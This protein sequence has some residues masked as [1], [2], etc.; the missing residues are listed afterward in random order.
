MSKN[1]IKKCY[2]SYSGNSKY[3]KS[4]EDLAKTFY[5]KNY[6]VKYRSTKLDEKS[7]HAAILKSEIVIVLVTE[8][9]FGKKIALK[10]FSVA[11]ENSKTILCLFTPGI[12]DNRNKIEN[13]TLK[14]M[15][16]LMV[17]DLPPE[18][19][20][21]NKWSKVI[22]DT[23]K[24]IEASFKDTRIKSGKILKEKNTFKIKSDP[25]I[26]NVEKHIMLGRGTVI[27]KTELAIIAF[28]E[29]S[30]E[31]LICTF[32]NQGDLLNTKNGKEIHLANPEL[33]ASNKN[34]E[35]YITNSNG[36]LMI[37]NNDLKLKSHANFE[38]TNYS[39]MAIDE[40]SN[41]IY[42]VKCLDKS[43]IRVIDYKSKTTKNIKWQKDEKFKSE[44][45]KPR[46]INVKNNQIVIV[47]ASSIRI[48]GDTREYEVQFGESFIYILDKESFSLNHF[49]DL[50][51]FG[52]CQPWNLI[53]DNDANIY[54]TVFQINDKKYVSKE[55]YFVKFDKNCDV[56]SDLQVL[57]NSFLSNELF[58]IKDQ[59]ILLTEKRLTFNSICHL[60]KKP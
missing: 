44:K 56:T 50:N 45:F 25:R 28:D 34:N 60:N 18:F 41:D 30:K 24:M 35:I 1:S 8:D 59:L 47:N 26:F 43:D 32:S 58:I 39:D 21:K 33:I 16:T 15:K 11:L 52:L 19:S 17:F 57:T 6:E 40:S 49:I 9:Y 4:L 37:Y 23:Y 13:E 38:L 20:L 54:T 3:N 14:I 22:N 2:L 36:L 7:A 46:F 5:E 31:H 55:R 53:V 29:Q 10:E 51:L 42:F 12:Y 27:N 48:D